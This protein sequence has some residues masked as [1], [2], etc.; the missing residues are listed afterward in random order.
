[1]LKVVL[2]V[3]FFDFLPVPPSEQPTITGLKATYRS[4]ELVR[5]N[6]TSPNSFPATKLEWK[7]NGYPVY[8][9]ESI[10]Y[11]M[12]K[13]TNEQ[14]TKKNLW[15]ETSTL[16]LQFL[17]SHQHFNEI[18]KIK[19]SIFESCLTYAT[20]TLTYLSQHPNQ[21]LHIIVNN[22]LFNCRGLNSNQP[23]GVSA[24]K[25]GYPAL[26]YIVYPRQESLLQA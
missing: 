8:L 24:R 1:M 17:I 11:P 15:L 18:G 7:I 5:S 14:L 20:T 25:N 6:C 13:T 2:I 21:M 3:L 12:T 10:Y 26:S 22:Q 23:H 19:V 9:G 16:G 4:G